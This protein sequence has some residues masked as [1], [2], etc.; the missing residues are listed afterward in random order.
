VT[1][2]PD[3]PRAARWL[4]R[5]SP[6]PRAMRAEVQADLHE[7]FL[8]RYVDRG[9]IHAHWR[10]Y[11]D[12]ASLWFQSRPAAPATTPR[13]RLAVI[14]DTRGDLKYAMRMFARQPAI[15]LLTI[16]GLSLGLGIATAAFSIMNAAV[17][18]RE[19]VVEPDRAPGILRAT[20]RSVATAWSYDEFAHLREGATRMRVEAV[21]RDGAVVRTT[22]DEADAPVTSLTFVSGG[23][24]DATGGRTIAGRT[25]GAADERPVGPPPVVVSFMFWTSRLN[26]DPRAIGRTIWIGRTTATIVGVA[27]RGFTVPGN[28]LLWMPLTAYDAVYSTRRLTGAPRVMVE[29][30][31]RL[32]PGVTLPE[33]EAQLN[34]VAGTLPGVPK[35]GES[36]IRARLDP[37]AGLGRMSSSSALGI[38]ILVFSVIGLVLLLTCTNV[39]TVLISTAI[40]RER[41]MG[42]RAALGAS[43]WRIAR[44]LVTESLALGAIASTIGLVFAYWTIPMIGTML[45]AP[46]GI[47]L[48]PDLNVYLFL[49]IVTL[50]SGVGAGLAPAWHSRGADLLTPLKGEGAREN[51]VTPR[52]LRSMLVMAQS[53]ASVILIILATL[54][55]R[56]TWRAATV[57]VGFDADSLYAVAPGLGSAFSG[58]AGVRRF[59]ARAM[60]ELQAVPDI[61]AVTLAEMAPF[62]GSVKTAITR[63]AAAHV[64]HLNRTRADYFATLGL[65]VLDGRT[66]TAGEIAAKAPVAL[67]S[68]S[69]ARAYWP[70]QSPTGQMLPQEIP[71]PPTTAPGKT[72]VIPAPRPVIIGVVA[73]A[74]TARLHESSTFAVYEPLD[75]DSEI[76]ARLLIRVAP[77]TTGAIQQASQR[78]R[79]IDPQ[80]NPRITSVAAGLRQEA[81]RPRMLATLTGFVGIVATILCVIGLYGVTA[82]VVGQRTREMGVRLAMGAQSSDLL[83]LLMWD[84]LR[85]VMFGLAIGV[86]AALLTSRGVASVTLF[87]VSPG[88]PLAF[89][90]AGAILLGAATLAVAMPTRRAAAIDAASVLR[91]S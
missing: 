59:W 63:D 64:V 1:H 28:S 79:A 77:G 49:G 85:P 69:L 30:F 32:L 60:P 3:L 83:R 37:H 44:Q 19:G 58:H 41:E 36:A 88:D 48:A 86:G 80:A 84:S 14:G 8:T 39:A 87:G 18:R 24:F 62:D 21:S 73:D 75:P 55:V 6:V 26:R 40:T 7:L 57:D 89:T 2:Q 90:G 11:H 70:G 38:T 25:F 22:T 27:E 52:R 65:R 16:A 66:F 72:V 91:Q 68:R 42:V 9:V 31:G 23:F 46:P 43:R 56:A 15:L 5:L 71:L 47:D 13:S 78:L 81:S 33:A 35:T 20:E 53:A 29:V 17:L 34:G 74:V 54:F 12:V 82:S 67:V 61:A 50:V 51:R 76:F 10:L 4:L 45:E